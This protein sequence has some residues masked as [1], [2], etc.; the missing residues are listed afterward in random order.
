MNER[1]K[2]REQLLEEV[3]ALL[4]KQEE[5]DQAERLRLVAFA[6]D[7]GGALTRSGSLP[8][9]LGRCAEAVVRHLEAALARIWTLDL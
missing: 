3:R 9:M 5:G 4:C 6:A 2:T 7:I 1:D 8:D